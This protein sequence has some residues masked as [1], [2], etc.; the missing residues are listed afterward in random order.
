MSTTPGKVDFTRIELADNPRTDL[1]DIDGLVASIK[2]LGLLQPLLVRH[3]KLGGVGYKMPDGSKVFA[4]YILKAGFRRYEAVRRIREEDKQAFKEVPVML[5]H[6]NDDD[7]R[8]AQIAENVQRKDLNPVELA[9]A[10]QE[11]VNKNYDTKDVA[12]RVGLT[13]QWV[14]RLLKVR[15]NCTN[16]VIK[17]LTKGEISVAAAYDLVDCTA[18]KQDKELANYKTTKET[19]GTKAAK[20]QTAKGAGK[21]VAPGKRIV[22]RLLAVIDEHE[23]KGDYWRGVS[24]ALSYT[25][26]EDE[27][28]MDE[29]EKE[30][31]KHNVLDVDEGE[32]PRKGKKS[33]KGKDDS[34]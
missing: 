12:E 4:R 30:A 8:F 7:A 10:L 15:Q 23:F 9:D 34:A 19:K 3:L 18:E 5:Y 21:K 31:Q 1:G 2:R 16:A 11:M 17:A 27:S 29:V 6:G 32:T 13:P 33:P 25:L 20:R 24:N 22:S 14:G 26:G 28:L